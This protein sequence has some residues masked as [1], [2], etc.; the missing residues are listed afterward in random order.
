MLELLYLLTD[1]NF[2]R[3]ESVA[4]NYSDFDS[5][6]A[7]SSHTTTPRPGSVASVTSSMSRE[8]L[9]TGSVKV[10]QPKLRE[11]KRVDSITP[12]TSSVEHAPVRRSSQAS[13]KSQDLT[14]G[15][16]RSMPE[17]RVKSQSVKVSEW[18]DRA[19]VISQESRI[20][21]STKSVRET[22]PRSRSASMSEAENRSGRDD[23]SARDSRIP[24]DS[25]RTK[26]GRSKARLNSAMNSDY[27]GSISDSDQRET[28]QFSEE[29]KAKQRETGARFSHASSSRSSTMEKSAG[30]MQNLFKTATEG[31]SDSNK[32]ILDEANGDE[33]VSR[34]PGRA[35]GVTV[36]S[37]S[38]NLRRLD[39]VI[40][41][42][43]FDEMMSA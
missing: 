8:T 11:A 14:S 13:I 9:V 24:R 39:S 20:S 18:S 19:S 43:E 38:S 5:Y 7:A 15:H 21:K 41:Q 10:E 1:Y 35:S 22:A 33:D 32:T 3:R 27:Q 40:G 37:E 12:L 42:L 34:D 28:I 26:S 30:R 25:R 4:S 2:C 29:M 6:K 16:S 31:L 23:T 36:S 17:A